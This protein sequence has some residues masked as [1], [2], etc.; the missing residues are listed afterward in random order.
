MAPTPAAAPA[1]MPGSITYSPQITLPQTGG[2]AT[3]IGSASVRGGSCTFPPT[4]IT[5][6][7]T[8]APRPV[9][10]RTPAHTFQPAVTP[11]AYRYQA[12]TGVTTGVSPT[13]PAPGM[14]QQSI[15][16]SVASS[17]YARRPIMGSGSVT[18]MP[19]PPAYYSMPPRPQYMSIASPPAPFT[20]SAPS[21]NIAPQF[22]MPYSLSPISLPQN[23]NEF[24]SQ[25]PTTETPRMPVMATPLVTSVAHPVTPE[26]T[27]ESFVMTHPDKERK[28][29]DVIRME[30]ETAASEPKAAKLKT[31]RTNKKTCC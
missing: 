25:M 21:Q 26:K 16:H 24:P 27:A 2:S 5:E 8:G 15:S 12:T 13:L 11:P 3:Y 4:A 19:Q 6:P 14:P 18:A 20:Y 30:N 28:P 7:M 10:S 22:Q 9:L 17:G 31:V 1:L 23:V 29:F